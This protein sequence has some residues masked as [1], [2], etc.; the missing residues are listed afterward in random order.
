[1]RRTL[2]LAAAALLTLTGAARASDPV[3]IYG[4]VDKVVLEPN[5]NKP[6]RVQVFGVFRLAKEKSGDEYEPAAYGYLYYDLAPGK[7]D[8]SR[9]EWADLKRVAGT[10]DAIAFAGR[11]QKLGKVRKAADKPDK[12]D[13]YPIANGLRR[14][15]AGDG[16][17]QE[18]RSLALPTE[19]ADGGQAEPGKV[20]L[21]ARAI[22]DKERKD[23]KYVFEITNAKGDKETSDPVEAGTRTNVASWTPKMQ[24]KQGEQ[25]TVRVW[26]VAGDWKGPALTT[27]FKGGKSA[28]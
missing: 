16:V 7:A 28:G 26:A 10:G 17:G 6:E 5:E 20:V 15:R 22:A 13:P 2:V 4:L 1:M 21:R 18:L 8:D 9:R 23:V 3:G 19:P 11:Y 24:V 14:L 25:Y 12:P 27:T